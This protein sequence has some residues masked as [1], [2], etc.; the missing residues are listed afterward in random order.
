M[1]DFSPAAET[2]IALWKQLDAM[3]RE[4]KGESIEADELRDRMDGPWRDLTGE[5]LKNVRAH[6]AKLDAEGRKQ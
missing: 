4:G 2:Y 3:W 6:L 1:T 5:D